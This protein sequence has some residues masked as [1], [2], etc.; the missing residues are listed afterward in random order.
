MNGQHQPDERHP[1]ATALAEYHAGLAAGRRGRRLAAHVANCAHCATVSDQLAAVSSTLASAPVPP[2]PDAVESRITAALANE[3]AL[4]AEASTTA[5]D[6]EAVPTEG[7]TTT[8]EP[9]HAAPR[10]LSGLGSSHRARGNTGPRGSRDDAP[11]P[12]RRARGG[13]RLRP[14]VLMSGAA[15]AV[16]VLVGAVFG[17]IHLSSGSSSPSAASSSQSAPVSGPNVPA[18][19]SGARA[20]GSALKAPFTV[21]MSGTRYEPATLA[22]QVRTELAGKSTGT[23]SPASARLASNSPPAQLAT[24]VLHLTKGAR[25]SLV[26]SATYQ[27]KSAYVIAVPDHAWVVGPGCRLIT[28]IGL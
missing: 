1:D 25:P 11:G 16:L 22:A 27:G 15:A 23:Q 7:P 6:P 10:S 24:C 17:L 20:A 3:A 2:L 4:R 18:P 28:S 19:A 9:R 26:D 12:P 5:A 21:I 14:A 13:R 8:D